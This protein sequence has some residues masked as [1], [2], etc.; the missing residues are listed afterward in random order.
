M[1]EEL[2]AHKGCSD[3]NKKTDT[4]IDIYDKFY[5]FMSKKKCWTQTIKESQKYEHRHRKDKIWKCWECQKSKK[6]FRESRDVYGMPGTY[7]DIA[8]PWLIL[9][10]STLKC[11][12]IKVKECVKQAQC[13]R[14]ENKTLGEIIQD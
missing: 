13:K 3:P 4:M 2:D 9:D 12:D 10:A 8:C 1:F 7:K 5:D 14:N 11:W 6:Q